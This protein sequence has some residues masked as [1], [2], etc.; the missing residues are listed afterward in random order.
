M[1]DVAVG[2]V[3]DAAGAVVDPREGLR[4]LR[5]GLGR[6]G[7]ALGAGLVLGFLVARARRR[8]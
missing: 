1:D 5:G 6:R 7:V 2:A 4:R 3:G 8:G